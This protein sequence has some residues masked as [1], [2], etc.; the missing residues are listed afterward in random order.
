[1]IYILAKLLH[2]VLFFMFALFPLWILLHSL[3]DT[4]ASRIS[5]LFALTFIAFLAK[6]T[7][8]DGFKAV[9]RKRILDTEGVLTAILKS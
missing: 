5:A 3:D 2:V 8:I 6:W 9:E 1:M 7:F 4:V